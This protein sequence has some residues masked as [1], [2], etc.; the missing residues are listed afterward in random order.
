MTTLF[1]QQIETKNIT[2]DIC[3]QD[4]EVICSWVKNQR[5]LSMVSGDIGNG[6][7]PAILNNWINNSICTIVI[8]DSIRNEPL[9][10]CTITTKE[11][12]TI[13]HSYI[14]LCHL[15]VNPNY[16]PKLEIGRQL[17]ISAFSNSLNM[18]FEFIIGRVAPFNNFGIILANDM[19]WQP[20]NNQLSVPVNFN[21]YIRKL[22]IINTM[23][24]NN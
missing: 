19:N 15:I 3:S 23:N 1:K 4:I 13:K 21:W 17:C 20:M 11:L 14:E 12:P 9:G 5:I 8:G 10:F 7:S 6:L 18:G 24:R 16:S 22:N 2:R